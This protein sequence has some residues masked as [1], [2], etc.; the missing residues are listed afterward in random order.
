MVRSMGPGEEVETERQTYHPL[1][2][3]TFCLPYEDVILVSTDSQC[4]GQLAP[5]V[6]ERR[7]A[8]APLGSTFQKSGEK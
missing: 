1:W 2:V 4:H 7:K 6:W 5:M 8:A 3:R